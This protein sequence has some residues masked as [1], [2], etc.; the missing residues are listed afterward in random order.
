MMNGKHEDDQEEDDDE[1]DDMTRA[2]ASVYYFSDDL[3]VRDVVLITHRVLQEFPSRNLPEFKPWYPSTSSDAIRTIRPKKSAPIISSEDLHNITNCLQEHHNTS[4]TSRAADTHRV[5][6]LTASD[7]TDE[8]NNKPEEFK[9]S[10]CVIRERTTPVI[11]TSQS[12][13]RLFSKIIDKHRLHL[14]Q[15]VKWIVCELNCVTFTVD[16]VWFQLNRAIRHSRLPTCNANFQRAL[17][18]IWIYCDVSY[19]EFIGN[20]L[21]DEFQLSGRITLTVHKLGDIIKF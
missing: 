19:C 8:F 4:D 9:R 13:S 12:F 11:K 14:H 18:Q 5:K 1:D 3:E 17:A 2:D 15:R 21:K 10:W 20:F 7:S 16:E 6:S